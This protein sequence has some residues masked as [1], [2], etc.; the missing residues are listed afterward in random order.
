[1]SILPIMQN[2]ILLLDGA[3]STML[4]QSGILHKEECPELLNATHPLDVLDIHAAYLDA[5]ADIITANTFGASTLRLSIFGLQDRME[6]L[7]QS[8]VSLCRE[9]AASLDRTVYIAAS[10]GPTGERIQS[11]PGMP[12]R[13]YD[14]FFQ[15]CAIAAAAGADILLIETMSDLCEARLALLAARAACQLPVFCSFILEPDDNTYAGNPPEVLG[16]CCAKLGAALCGV[17]CGLGPEE[18]FLGYSRLAGASPL[19]AFAMPNAGKPLNG[20]YSL[21]PGAMATAMQPYLHS[22]AAAIGGCC[23]T[24]PEHIRALRTL[25]N[26]FHGHARQAVPDAE[27]ICSTSLRLPLD[28]LEPFELFNLS[29]LSA[30][31]AIDRVSALCK[32][33]KALHLDLADLQADF[34][35]SILLSLLPKIGKIPVAFHV[36]NAEQAHAALFVYPGIAA[37]YAHSD[38][39]RVH[40]AAARYGA[41]I[42]D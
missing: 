37:V 33:A 30:S 15:Q 41:E 12:Q 29:G 27:A 32:E 1:M 36:H 42:V 4:S 9:A 6:E 5:G 2:H 16:L 35:R 20:C 24:A 10:I 38:A 11:D 25:L 31:Q 14:S 34:I 23:G 28:Q 22:G 19:P 7:I 3:I 39:Y 8:G 40:K 26:D 21:S 18:L 17:N 13:M